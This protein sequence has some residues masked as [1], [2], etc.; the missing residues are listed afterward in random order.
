MILIGSSVEEE[1]EEKNL[2]LFFSFF[3]SLCG[4]RCCRYFSMKFT[5]HMLRSPDRAR[6]HSCKL[7]AS[8]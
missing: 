2:V 5:H 4:R 1:E 8:P 6:V 3:F 7:S